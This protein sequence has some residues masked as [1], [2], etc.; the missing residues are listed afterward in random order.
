M[1]V[2]KDMGAA[3]DYLAPLFGDKRFTLE[4][5]MGT[6]LNENIR[7]YKEDLDELLQERGTLPRCAPQ[8]IAAEH[9]GYRL[10]EKYSMNSF[11]PNGVEIGA[12]PAAFLFDVGQN[13]SSTIYHATQCSCKIFDPACER[14]KETFEEFSELEILAPPLKERTKNQHNALFLASLFSTAGTRAAENLGYLL[15]KHYG[16]EKIRQYARMSPS[17]ALQFFKD[18]IDNEMARN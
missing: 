9:V 11:V 4:R 15:F 1:G 10:F 13:Y 12:Q 2:I 14:L 16:A 5:L 7:Y 17:E 3:L 18:T 6:K 8:R